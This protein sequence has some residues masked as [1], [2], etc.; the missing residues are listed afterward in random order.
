MVCLMK[1]REEIT[2]LNIYS[3]G[4]QQVYSLASHGR[5][6]AGYMRMV[7]KQNLNQDK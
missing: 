6:V 3:T 1:P 5:S 2:R 4:D 7:V